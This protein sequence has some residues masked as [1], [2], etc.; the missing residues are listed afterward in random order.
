MLRTNLSALA[1]L[2]A[3]LAATDAAA[4]PPETSRPDGDILLSRYVSD[5]PLTPN[6]RRGE[7]FAGLIHE[8]SVG[9]LSHDH[10]LFSHVK[11]EDSLDLH[12]EV[13]MVSP[14]VLEVI[15]SPYP[16]VGANINNEGQ[17][18]QVFAGL[19]W[20]W[21][22]DLGLFAGVSLGG[23]LHN[24]ETGNAPPNRKALGCPLLFRESVNV[25]YRWDEHNGIALVADHISNA[26][27]CDDNESLENTGLRY[28]YRF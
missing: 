24:G 13:R 11:E 3:G 15:G 23:A 5:D 18:S 17:T 14:E 4:A 21:E 12:L 9:V 8:I 16:H 28:Q 26:N 19:S 1:A 6:R 27:L 2:V 7:P 25:G 10:G 22:L 20:E